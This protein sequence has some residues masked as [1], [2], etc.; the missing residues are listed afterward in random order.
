MFTVIPV[1]DKRDC[2]EIGVVLEKLKT[3]N[4]TYYVASTAVSVGKGDSDLLISHNP[5]V[6]PS[7]EKVSK[8]LTLQLS[9]LALQSLVR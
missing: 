2:V 7:L 6:E 3:P 5:V 4:K 8:A 9:V 1:S